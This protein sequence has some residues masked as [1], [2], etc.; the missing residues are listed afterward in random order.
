M[1]FDAQQRFVR[2]GLSVSLRIKNYVEDDP[3]D[4]T[5]T[6]YLEVGV[7]FSPTGGPSVETGYVDIPIDPPPNVIN[8]TL[9][10]IGEFGGRFGF[11]SCKFI[12]SHTFV[13]SMMDTYGITDPNTVWRNFNGQ[14]VIGLVYD[15][16]IQ[17]IEQITPKALSGEYIC[18]HLTCN[19]LEQQ[20]TEAP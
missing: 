8:L 15:G 6:E 12:V 17:S 14:K 18:W 1:L 10:D 3:Q 11:G 7:P 19:A 5:S 9:R 20:T 16:R 13:L 2:S 4:G